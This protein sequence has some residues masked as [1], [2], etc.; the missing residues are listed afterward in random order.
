MKAKIF[1][2]RGPL[3]STE[4]LEWELQKQGVEL[5]DENPDF[6]YEMCGLYDEAEAFCA[7]QKN[8]PKK[9]YSLLDVDEGKDISFYNQAVKHL[10][11]A[12]AV[13]AISNVVR[14][15][16]ENLLGV[17][18]EIDILHFPIREI[19]NE[20]LPWEKKLFD[21]LYVGRVFS[22]NKRFVLTNQ[23]LSEL[24]RPNDALCVVGP[25][26]PPWGAYGGLVSEQELN[27]A[28]NY[29]RF[30]L[31]PSSFEG[32]GCSALE[33]TAASI[34]IVCSDCKAIHE[35]GLSD[36]AAEPNGNALARKVIDI[37]NNRDYYYEKLKSFR[38]K[39]L[40]DFYVENIVE[41]LIKIYER[42]K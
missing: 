5:V 12:D 42:V 41:K 11:G 20:N 38:E 36:F 9:I 7:K 29:A 23:L 6:V 18:K 19:K 35:F 33:A 10:E 4:K 32:Q 15:Q 25:E 2:Y 14:E 34:P 37:A 8:Q 22:P 16:I 40:K 30:V 24:G 1:G 13:C 28:Y 27:I 21:F 3:N 31:M 39:K 26:A 17:K